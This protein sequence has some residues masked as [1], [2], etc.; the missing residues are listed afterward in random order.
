MIEIKDFEEYI[1]TKLTKEERAEVRKEAELEVKIL[2]S[3]KSFISSSLEEYMAENK[4]GFNELVAKL[5]SSPS[6]LSKIKK[7][8]ANLTIESVAHLM[9]TMGKDPDAIDMFKSK[10]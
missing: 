4:V 1:A 10:K 8:Q 5:G 7:G 2:K 9:A 3:I 6:H